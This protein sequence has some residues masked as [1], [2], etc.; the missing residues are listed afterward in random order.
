MRASPFALFSGYANGREY[1]ATTVSTTYD[2]YDI[3]V[4]DT[5]VRDLE[6]QNQINPLISLSILDPLFTDND[7]TNP[8]NINRDCNRIYVTVLRDILRGQEVDMPYL[9]AL[10][11]R[12]ATYTIV[13]L[14]DVVI[15]DIHRALGLNAISITSTGELIYPH[16]LD[17]MKGHCLHGLYCTLY[18]LIVYGSSQQN[19]S[20]NSD[21]HTNVDQRR[22]S[23]NFA[24]AARW[25]IDRTTNTDTDTNAC[26]ALAAIGAKFGFDRVMADPQTRENWDYV[27]RVNSALSGDNS[28]VGITVITG[29]TTTT[30][31]PL[32]YGLDDFDEL[33]ESAHMI[34]RLMNF[35]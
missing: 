25:I 16:Q 8:N 28:S 30:G 34:Y 22:P 20:D 14:I 17:N 27:R 35:C 9:R 13:I 19:H 29:T 7:L 2:N 18:C 5:G 24:L 26:I 33:T 1:G 23:D 4:D 10:Q 21:L 6:G 3:S 31:R 12:A 15:A 32:E 11:Q